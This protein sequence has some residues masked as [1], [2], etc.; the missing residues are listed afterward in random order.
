MAEGGLHPGRQDEGHLQPPVSRHAS[1]IVHQHTSSPTTPKPYYLTPSRRA[2]PI[3][4]SGAR[5]TVSE[6]GA[7]KTAILLHRT[8]QSGAK[9][10]EAGCPSAT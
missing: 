3:A 10:P 5:A 6:A 9:P 7:P 2:T 8:T 1:T 4:I